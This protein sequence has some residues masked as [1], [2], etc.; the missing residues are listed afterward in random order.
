MKTMQTQKNVLS[1]WFLFR[2]ENLQVYMCVRVSKPAG[3]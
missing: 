3:I 1:V 2:L